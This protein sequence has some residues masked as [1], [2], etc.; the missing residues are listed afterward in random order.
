MSILT[1]KSRDPEYKT[2]GPFQTHFQERKNVLY[3]GHVR[4]DLMHECARF[5]HHSPA[6]QTCCGRLPRCFEVGIPVSTATSTPTCTALASSCRKWSS[7]GRRT[8]CWTSRP[9]VGRKQDLCSH[10][11]CLWGSLTYCCM[12][13]IDNQ[14]PFGFKRN[15]W[16]F[17][18][19]EFAQ[20]TLGRMLSPPIVQQY[21]LQRK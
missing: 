12:I 7:G 15:M 2:T 14:M 8:A 5:M 13:Y 10:L 1:F 19:Q 6:S 16:T 20:G 9:Q 17:W 3:S 11:T 4:V 21:M 18:S